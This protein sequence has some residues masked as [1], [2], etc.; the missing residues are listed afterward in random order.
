MSSIILVGGTFRDLRA[1]RVVEDITHGSVGY[2]DVGSKNGPP[3]Y[4]PP[5]SY[6]SCVQLQNLPRP[7]IPTCMFWKLQMPVT[8]K[9]GANFPGQNLSTPKAIFVNSRFVAFR[10]HCEITALLGYGL[11]EKKVTS[12]NKCFCLVLRFHRF[13][14]RAFWVVIA[15]LGFLPHK[16]RVDFKCLLST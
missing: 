4:G 3:K 16:P 2:S 12:W 11:E 9:F 8:T 6:G 10:F 14:W 7:F 13:L 15:F 5:G 1:G